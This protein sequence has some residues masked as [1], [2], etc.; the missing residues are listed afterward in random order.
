[1][2][3]AEAM[4]HQSSCPPSWWEFSVNHAVH[5][6]NRTPV[7]RLDWRTPHQLLSGKVPDVSHLRVFG[8]LA[9]VWISPE[10]RKSKLSPKA[11]PMVFLGIPAGVKGYLFMRLS[12]NSMHIGV[13]AMFNKTLFPKAEGFKIPCYTAV[14]RLGE[15][16]SKPS[17]TSSDSP[18]EEIPDKR[19][20]CRDIPT[21]SSEE[22]LIGV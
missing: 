2:D 21:P 22:K 9:W 1:M 6:Y 17:D 10:A 11:V 5:L 20:K 12:N 19:G 15:D 3:K 7:R 16:G 13:K 14:H 8:C 4:R 18:Q